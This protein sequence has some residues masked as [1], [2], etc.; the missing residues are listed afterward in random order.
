M[1]VFNGD[2]AEG[3]TLG[4][5]WI[6]GWALEPPAVFWAGSDGSGI[7]LHGGCAS[8]LGVH[9]LKD[10]REYELA[11]GGGHWGKRAARA[12]GAALRA[13]EWGQEVSERER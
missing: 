5:C 8:A 1:I 13:S 11:V 2:L 3:Q 7:A 9:L 10:V 12:A 6:C 4:Y